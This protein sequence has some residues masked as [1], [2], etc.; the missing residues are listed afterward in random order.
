MA[1]QGLVDFLKQGIEAWNAWKAKNP[2]AEIDL[3]GA[4]LCHIDLRQANLRRA[5]LEGANLSCAD[6][7]QAG[8]RDA[9]LSGANLS[10]ANLSNADLHGAIVTGTQFA[11][12][13]GLSDVEIEA[14]QAR[15]A[16][17]VED[18]PPN[19]VPRENQGSAHRIAEQPIIHKTLIE[20]QAPIKLR[21]PS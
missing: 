6:L 13:L 16:T 19:R 4:Q 7:S 14:L 5:S 10:R 12:S 8:L 17:F 11:L 9:N 1:N 20:K 15:G 21:R 18:L 3:S 2:D